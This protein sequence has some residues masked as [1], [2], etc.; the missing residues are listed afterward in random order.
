M[1]LT[2]RN[3]LRMLQENRGLPNSVKTS[4]PV[5]RGLGRRLTRYTLAVLA[6]LMSNWLGA[7]H[8]QA[9]ATNDAAPRARTFAFYYGANPPVA[10]LSAFDAVVVEP[11][12]G[13]DPGHARA[14]NTAWFAYV[15]VGEVLPSAPYYPDLPK[16]WLVGGNA[17]WGSRVVNQA[18]P[19]W[20]QFYVDHVIAPLWARGYRGFFLDTLDSYQLYAKNDAERASAQAGMVAVVKAIKSRYPQAKLIFNRGFEILPQVHDQVYALAFESLFQGWNQAEQ[21]YTE[22]PQSDRDWLMAQAK[23]AAGYGLPVISI[24]YCAPAERRCARDTAAKI[25]ALG[26]IPYVTDPLLGTVGVGSIEVQPRS[27]LVLQDVIP[28]AAL[29]VSAGL[30]YIGMPVNYLGYRADYAD[31]A[32]PLP[33]V[34]PDRYAG[35]VLWMNGAAPHPAE[36]REWLMRTI[37][38]GVPVAVL[39]RFGIPVD[40]ALAAKLGLST[41]SGTPGAL[42][43]VQSYDPKLMGFEM[44]PT[45]NAQDYVPLKVGASGRSL[46]KLKTGTL[47]FDGAA[48]MPWGGFALQ[49]YAVF[50]LESIDQARWVLQPLDFLRQALRLPDMPVPDTTTENGRRLLM[51]HI[52][53]DGFAS[54]AEFKD[55]WGSVYSG[56]VLYHVL[57]KFGLPTTVSVI[58]SEVSDGGPFKAYA[59]SLR[60]SARRLFALPN[61]EMASHTYT[62][63]LQWMRVTGAGISRTDATTEGGSQTD[64]SGLSYNIPGYTFNIQREIG[65]SIDYINRELAPPGKA[66]KVLLWSGDCQVPGVVVKAAYDAG[67]T[68][69][70]GGDT[71]ITKSYPSWTAIAPLG[72]LKDGYYQIFA[73]NQNEELYTQLWQGPYYGFERA[74]ETYQMTDEPIRFKPV[75]VY[76]HMFSGTKEASVK[77]LD[78]VYGALVRQALNPVFVSEYTA[79]V[80]DFQRLSIARD[81]AYWQVRDAGDLR[82]VRLAPGHVPELADSTGVAGYVAGPGGVYVH[83]SGAQARFR[84]SEVGADGASDPNRQRAYLQQANGR[85][86]NF[87]STASS[88]SFELHSYLAPAFTIAHA[89]TCRVSANGREVHPLPAAAGAR[90]SSYQLDTA[91]VTT[92]SANSAQVTR[93]NV[94]CAI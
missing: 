43:T 27:I 26:V 10:E 82:T 47:E 75:D 34:T 51:T 23:T 93:I 12:S 62:H 54:K 7:A 36:L 72:A 17:A 56:D 52:D 76:Y 33:R 13:F 40:G 81:G 6:L 63:P 83:L 57:K 70:N 16:Q 88:M 25:K 58:E 8:A 41:A 94:D 80:M 53:G 14:P 38:A 9:P 3:S 64:N 85:L 84:V 35:A 29:D 4:A 55:A 68:N 37:D 46:L 5:L 91:E 28:R 74:L 67:V 79:K 59:A 49:P 65:G 42:M 87:S 90:S 48:L 15:S 89:G 20:P 32:M 39:N 66:V 60:T 18:A 30:R 78:A 2:G 73:P 92:H 31:V 11:T 44:K 71:L 19:G 86:E 1:E 69:L 61:V 77:A 21:R 24:D 45:P 50:E 22:V